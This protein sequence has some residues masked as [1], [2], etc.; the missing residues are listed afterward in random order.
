M[1]W[2]GI[3]WLVFVAS[4]RPSARS[5]P[6]DAGQVSDAEI[7]HDAGAVRSP[8]FGRPVAAVRW[9]GAVGA[10]ARDRATGEL[11]FAKIDDGAGTVTAVALPAGLDDP[12]L[13]GS[14]NG[15]GVIARAAGD[16]GDGRMLLRLGAAREPRAVPAVSIGAAA[17][18]TE[19]GVYAMTRDKAGWKGSF[20]PLGEPSPEPSSVTLSGRSEATI[21]CGRHRAFAVLSGSGELRAIAW[22]PT[23]HDASPTVLPKP[24]T[25]GDEDTAM[26]TMD[27]DLVI[28]KLERSVVHTLV[29]KGE[30]TSAWRKSDAIAKEGL[31]LEAVDA[32]QGKIGLL[33]VRTVAKA[34]GCPAGETSDAVAEVA[35]VD[36][37]SGKLVHAPESIET[38]K[39]G[40]EPGPFFLGWAG[41]KLVVAWPRG[42]DAACTR[43]GVKRGGVGYA[44]VDPVT[45]KARVGRVARPAE[46]IAPA[47]CD[48]A[49]CYAVALTR[50]SDPC[51]PSD[52]PEAG[53]LDVIAYP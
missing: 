19:D 14:A 32:D 31:A 27:D 30:G 29:W 28:V 20:F 7:S 18:A 38:W 2:L 10:V 15:L 24:A 25:A 49:K 22:T 37:A 33:F 44:E 47:G 41:G 48:E 50:G 13:V 35:L 45:G 6:G 40:A 51:G 53:R 8:H 39:C 11:A 34:K 26:A 21:V 5:A 12:E 52:G 1:R 36:P 16:A 17:C 3:A 9:T 43:A 23:K 46:T 42:A 4:C